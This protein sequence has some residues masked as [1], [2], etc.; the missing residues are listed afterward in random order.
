[1]L[2]HGH[3]HHNA[4]VGKSGSTH[5]AGNDMLQREA[6]PGRVGQAQAFV[7]VEE[8]VEVGE[9]DA[10]GQ[11]AKQAL[12]DAGPV[13]GG[14]QQQPQLGP[15]EA[16]VVAELLGRCVS[17]LQQTKDALV[18]GEEPWGRQS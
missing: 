15:C 7:G 16:L 2:Y 4:I 17:P 10:P 8:V 13:D 3:R 12:R 14:P 11:A 5:S 1:M 9:Q 18:G 6:H